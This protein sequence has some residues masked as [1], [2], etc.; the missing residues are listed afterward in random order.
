MASDE[1]LFR[2]WLKSKVLLD[3]MEVGLNTPFLEMG[4]TMYSA[5]VR[6]LFLIVQ[7]VYLELE[8]INTFYSQT[9]DIYI[10]IW[11]LS[12]RTIIE[13]DKEV[14]IRMTDNALQM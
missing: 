12:R 10:E 11:W 2:R 3:A 5:E 13:E 9:Q 1:T 6:E 7:I 8:C 14:Q 4:D